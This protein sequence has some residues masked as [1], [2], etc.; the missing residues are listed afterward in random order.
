MKMRLL[1][2][3]LVIQT[4]Q[5]HLRTHKDKVK[6]DFFLLLFHEIWSTAELEEFTKLLNTY[7]DWY[8]F[9]F[10][11]LPY[12]MNNIYEQYHTC[13]RARAHASARICKH[14]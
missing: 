4:L 6:K 2:D 5:T 11:F 12:Q 1:G 3:Y 8:Q 14:E 10:L 7:A 13:V 9:L